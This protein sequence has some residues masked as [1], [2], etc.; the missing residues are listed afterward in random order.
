MFMIGVKVFQLGDFTAVFA[1]GSLAF[2]SL[3]TGLFLF[4]ERWLILDRTEQRVIRTSKLLVPVRQ[5]ASPLSD[6][7]SVALWYIVREVQSEDGDYTRSG[8]VITL[9]SKEGRDL[10]C[11]ICSYS[12][13]ASARQQAEFL[14]RFLNL[15]VNDAGVPVEKPATST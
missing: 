2:F 14:S 15:P 9:R 1:S 10:D 13:E 7:E 4:W 11:E 6:F 5:T 8:Y 3:V 12:D